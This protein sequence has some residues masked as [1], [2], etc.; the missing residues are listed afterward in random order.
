MASFWSRVRLKL[1]RLTLTTSR[2][3]RRRLDAFVA[4]E[5]TEGPVL[6]VHSHDIDLRRH[7]PNAHHL[8]PRAEAPAEPPYAEALH[9]E[10]DASRTVVVCTGLLEHVPRPAETMAEIARILAP[11]GRL[12]L[13]ASAVFPF[14]G[15][16]A[17]YYHFTPG[18]MRA[19]LSG[20]FEIERMQGST[21]PFETL[22]VLSQRICL[23]CDVAAPVRLM[24]EAMQHVLPLFDRFIVRQYDSMAKERPCDPRLGIMPATLMLVAVRKPQ[25]TP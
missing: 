1:Q 20:Q 25:E 17:N 24:L 13:S 16:P 6:A 8:S 10:P 22:G 9:A 7:F 4:A 14:H 21:G 18:G 5:A 23:Q 15:A 11:G 12:V 3:T 2:P 19:L